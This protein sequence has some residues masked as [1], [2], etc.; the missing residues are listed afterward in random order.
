MILAVQ[1]LFEVV[2]Q[3]IQAQRLSRWSARPRFNHV[4]AALTVCNCWSSAL[5]RHYF[6]HSLS[7]QRIVTLLLDCYLDFVSAIVVPFA[8]AYPYI[9]VYDPSS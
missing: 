4:Y 8:L 7:L 2:L 3:T 1:E 5:V 9:E 6:R